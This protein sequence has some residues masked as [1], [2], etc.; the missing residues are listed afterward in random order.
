M[1]HVA[2]KVWFDTVVREYR[3]KWNGSMKALAKVQKDVDENLPE[4]GDEDGFKWAHRVVC[5]EK[6]EYRLLVQLHEYVFGSWQLK[7]YDP[8]EDFLDDLKAIDHVTDVETSNAT[9]QPCWPEIPTKVEEPCA[10]C[11]QDLP[12]P[13]PIKPKNKKPPKKKKEEAFTPF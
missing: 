3:L 13:P 5:T 10:H 6:F 1:P 9:L 11:N 12:K 7:D 8:E 2:W 4:M